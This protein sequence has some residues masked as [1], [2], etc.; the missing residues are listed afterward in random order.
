MKVKAYFRAVIKNDGPELIKDSRFIIGN[1]GFKPN[2]IVV[3]PVKLVDQDYDDAITWLTHNYPGSR[4][5]NAHD[6][7][8]WFFEDS[9]VAFMFRLRWC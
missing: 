2:E 3:A 5:D 9:D 7:L 1:L 6:G 4:Y 8:D